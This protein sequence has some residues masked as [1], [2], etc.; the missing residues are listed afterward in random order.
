MRLFDE[1]LSIDDDRLIPGLSDLVEIIL[2]HGSKAVLQ[3]HYGCNITS[4]AVT[5]KSVASSSIA[6]PGHEP[7]RKLTYGEIADIITR[8]AEGANRVRQGLMT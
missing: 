1:Q 7:S 3:L 8:F 2:N 6:K 4:L 5:V